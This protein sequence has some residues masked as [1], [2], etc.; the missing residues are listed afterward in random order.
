MNVAAGSPHPHGDYDPESEYKIKSIIGEN[1]THYHI[2]WEDDEITGEQYENTWEPKKFANQLA[3]DDW[4]EQKAGRSQFLR[5]FDAY[6]M[7]ANVESKDLNSRAE[8]G[9][10]AVIRRKR[11][12]HRSHRHRRSPPLQRARKDVHERLSRAPRQ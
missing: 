9:Q 6:R 7:L 1:K 4:K 3:I 8:T 5:V 10:V 12:S 11:L 2:S